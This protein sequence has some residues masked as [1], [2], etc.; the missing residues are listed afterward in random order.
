MG[1][2]LHSM[3]IS[4]DDLLQCYACFHCIAPELAIDNFIELHKLGSAGV[5]RI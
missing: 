5:R 3:I 2:V 1:E 4:W